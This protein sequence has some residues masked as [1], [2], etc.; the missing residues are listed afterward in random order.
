MTSNK[1]PLV[2]SNS[3]RGNDRNTNTYEGKTIV[4]NSIS[5]PANTSKNPTIY[6][7][8]LD[9]LRSG[10]DFWEALGRGRNEPTLHL[11]FAPPPATL[12]QRLTARLRLELAREHIT[13]TALSKMSGI[14]YRKVR[15]ALRDK[16][17]LFAGELS[18]MAD[19]L[20]LDLPEMFRDARPGRDEN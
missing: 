9:C 18:D 1:R 20:G 14:S 13:M 16:R 17:P 3:A 8:A 7:L 15:G 10:S 12:T 4:K 19:A 5:L 6:A 2:S 11:Q